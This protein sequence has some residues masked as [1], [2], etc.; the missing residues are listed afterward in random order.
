[1]HLNANQWEI[2]G[3]KWRENFASRDDDLHLAIAATS[4]RPGTIED[5]LFANLFFSSVP[6]LAGS[7]L[8]PP[9]GYEYQYADLQNYVHVRQL[10]VHAHWAIQVIV[11]TPPS[12]LSGLLCPAG[13]IS[14]LWAAESQHSS[15]PQPGNNL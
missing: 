8:I 3:G 13:G 7:R 12:R 1:M 4:V 9:P 15:F 5:L 2:E 6:V 11:C 14:V 10:G